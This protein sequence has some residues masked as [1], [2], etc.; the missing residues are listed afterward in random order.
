MPSIRNPSRQRWS[1]VVFASGRMHKR[2]NI[3]ATRHLRQITAMKFQDLIAIVAEEPV[4]ET[5]L[6]LAG[7][8]DPAHVR[9]QL[10]RWVRAGRVQ[11]LRRGLYALA[12][13]WRKRIP[14]P[15]LVANRLAPDS[16]VS[17]LSALAFAHAIPE[18]AAPACAFSSPCRAT[19][20]ISTSPWK[21]IHPDT[22][23]GAICKP[24]ARSS[25]PSNTGSSCASGNI[26][27]CTASWC[28]SPA[29]C[30]SLVCLRTHRKC[31]RSR[32]RST[33]TPPAGAGLE[34]SLV[35]RHTTLRLYHHDRSSLLAGK[36]HAVLRRPCTKGRDLYDLIWYL[37]A[38]DWPAPNLS[39]LNA[40]L[41]QNGWD[42]EEMVPDSW[43]H[44]VRDRL[45]VLDWERAT[46][47]VRPFLE[48]QED[49]ELVTS[50]NALELLA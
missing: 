45:D 22:P 49:V 37:S 43:R 50:A 32:S 21:E 13:P 42:G 19:R 2:L 9:R 38:P 17:G 34:V 28:V 40:A 27:R 15:F 14:H 23:C 47:D 36:L 1:I 48:R 7:P 4:F 5:G 35:R 30:T 41:Y 8:G 16:Y 39:L 26:V 31:L 25:R 20:K 12:P 24:F 44:R 29:C 3:A 18:R 46:A 11:Q 33:P 10:S 6:L